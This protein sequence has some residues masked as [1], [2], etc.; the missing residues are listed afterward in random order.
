MA[1]EGLYTLPLS[2]YGYSRDLD[3]TSG[4]L[5]TAVEGV[6]LHVQARVDIHAGAGAKLVPEAVVPIVWK[7]VATADDGTDAR[8]LA[9]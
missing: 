9:A 2:H 7:H 6:N 5:V 1:A 8:L 4:C 3:V